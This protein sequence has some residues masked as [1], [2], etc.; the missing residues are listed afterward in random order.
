MSEIKYTEEQKEIIEYSKSG[1]NLVINAYAGAGKT[2][3]L[4]AIAE[5]N[6]DK[7]ILYLAYNKAIQKE[8]SKKFPSNT[9][10]STLHGL[11]YRNIAIGY[12]NKQLIPRLNNRLRNAEIAK[13]L[14]VERS[15]CFKGRETLNIFKNSGDV[16]IEEKH[17]PKKER[18][19]IEKEYK[20]KF[21][22]EDVKKEILAISRVLWEMEIDKKSSYPITHDT[23]LKL[24][25]LSEPSL[26]EYDIILVD[27]AQDTNPVIHKILKSIKATLILVG[28]S[29]QSIYQWRGSKNSLKEY[30]EACKELWLTKSFRFG[31]SVANK[32]TEIIRTFYTTSPAVQALDS[33]ETNIT[34]GSSF[35]YTLDEPI[36]LLYRTNSGVA[37]AAISKIEEGSSVKIVGG[38]TELCNDLM[39]I[40]LLSINQ[41]KTGK[42]IKYSPFLNYKEVME[43]AKQVY[44]IQKDINFISTHKDNTPYLVERLRSA[45]NN[46]VNDRDVDF[47]ISTTHKA[48]G[49]EWNNVILGD[50]F[51][52]SK[53]SEPEWNLVYVAMT[54]AKNNLAYP[55]AID[56][57]LLEFKVENRKKDREIKKDTPLHSKYAA[58]LPTLKADNIIESFPKKV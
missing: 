29:H 56:R 14:G 11:A 54:R 36:A 44:E 52:I 4:I 16:Y 37:D 45:A 15:I 48:K 24:Y 6:P 35:K 8:A 58:L 5:A 33:K 1:K 41:R 12:Y 7:T 19:R 9:K 22:Q 25:Q 27:E 57:A 43:E 51:F 49:L 10:V 31:S 3:T 17:I 50:D 26:A 2:S 13:K 20:N 46:S 21:D 34:K 18:Q 23:Y 28:D 55:E 42:S 53:K 30:R 39:D 32:A 47:I 38:V 40:Y